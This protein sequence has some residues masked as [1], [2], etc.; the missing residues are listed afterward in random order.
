MKKTIHIIILTI[1]T[2]SCITPSM[3]AAEKS[4]NSIQT[5]ALR[6]DVYYHWG[7]IWKKAGSGILTLD[8]DSLESGE[9]RLHGKLAGRSLSIVE[10]LMR[11]RDTLHSYM[12]TEYVPLEYAKLTHEGSYN[13]WERNYYNYL[14][15][16]PTELLT[17]G[18]ID[19]TYVSIRRWRQ[20]KGKSQAEY[21]IGNSGYDML[22]IF[23]ILR[24]QDFSRMPRG[25]EMSYD[26]FSGIKKTRMFAKYIGMET[27][28]MRN[29]NKFSSYR[30][31]LY[32]KSKDSDHT[33][34]HVWLSTD[35]SHKPLKVIIQLKRI[36]SIQGELVQ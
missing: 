29:G 3:Q 20:S 13:A 12:T 32:F 30:L 16:N 6:Y 18:N 14:K 36:G 21:T 34:L 19:S 26:I 10:T 2:L 24:N 15:K 8:I 33:P 31:E 17:T 5:E 22:S 11:V 23:Y 27:C 25:K 28:E 35:P 7:F 4:V 1:L 9:K